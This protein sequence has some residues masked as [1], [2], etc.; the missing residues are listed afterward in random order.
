MATSTTFRFTAPGIAALKPGATRQDY[1]DLDTPGFGIRVTPSGVKSWFL[2][3]RPNGSRTQR[4]WTIGRYSQEL[5]LAKARALVEIATGRMSQATLTG[6]RF[7]PSEDKAARR[8]ARTFGQLAEHYMTDHAKV[9]KKSWPEDQRQ[10]DHD[11]LPKWRNVAVTD[12]TA[13]RI[14]SLLTEIGERA[15]SVAL[16][17]R[18]LLSKMFN[19]A[20]G[21]GYGVTYNPISGLDRAPKAK[22][23][24]RFLM[25]N[26]L[27]AL[28]RALDLEWSAGHPHTASWFAL[29]VL[30]AQRPGEVLG[31]R[32]SQ[33]DIFDE[34][35]QTAT[36]GWWT[37]KATKNGD[38]VMAALSSHAVTFLRT[39]RRHAESEHTRVEANMVGRRDPRP[40]S[41]YVF[42]AG[43][44]ARSKG[45]VYRDRPMSGN[46]SNVCDRIRARIPSVEHFTPHDL[47]R[48]AGTLITRL[49]HTRFIMDRVMNHTDDSIGGVY[50][51]F[52]YAAERMAAVSSVGAHVACLA[53]D[54]A[55]LAKTAAPIGR[56]RRPRAAA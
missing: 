52:E 43:S 22:S 35:N 47:R 42:P 37:V 51:R 29:I 30:T 27:A 6:E 23:C 50:D 26:E 14:S 25:D 40:F 44:R 48:T 49:G 28:F 31:M 39:L 19:F 41:A 2:R 10:L 34:A 3:Y 12:V 18:R 13:E 4:R 5:G 7:D 1:W 8:E 45:G 9:H 55:V 21:R 38:P 46:Q 24:K 16:H 56:G 53:K 32:W 54:H 36:T 17:L 20:K 33:L 15:P 11:L